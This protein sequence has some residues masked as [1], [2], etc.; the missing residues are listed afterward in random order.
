LS[1]QYTPGLSTKVYIQ[2]LLWGSYTQTRG[3]LDSSEYHFLTN[4]VAYYISEKMVG[5]L[6]RVLNDIQRHRLSCGLM[7]R[8]LA[9]PPPLSR[10]QVV[11][12]SQSS[13]VSPAE[14]TNE[15]GKGWGRARSQIIRPRESLALYKS[16]NTLCVPHL[17]WLEYIY[18]FFK[19]SLDIF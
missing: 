18:I 10:E 12:H 11:S 9:H 14:H 19:S 1:L 13:C 6:Q 4:I 7:I 16:L 17:V 2:L 8:L 15:R 5:N 3:Q